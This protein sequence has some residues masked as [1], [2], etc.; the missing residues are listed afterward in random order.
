MLFGQEHVQKY[1][2]TDG[3][4]GH[5]W[6]PGV[7]TLLL[8][9]TGRNSGDSYTTPLIFG[10]D[11][12]DYVVVASKGGADE[13]PDWYRNL[14]AHP[15]VEIQVAADVMAATAR[16]VAGDDRERLWSSMA[17]I[18]PD[19]NEYATKTDRQIPVVVITPS[20]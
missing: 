2:E 17:E 15:S 5:E 13:H 10:E 19:Y 1:R 7:Y 9:T 20:P 3:E 4:V 6:Q 11:G 14:E 8:T 16:T 12:D 18:W